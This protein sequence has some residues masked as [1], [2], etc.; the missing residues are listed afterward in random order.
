MA[1]CTHDGDRPSSWEPTVV[2]MP[3]SKIT[4][5]PLK[6]F[7]YSTYCKQKEP[8][9]TI[10]ACELPHSRQCYLFQCYF[11]GIKSHVAMRVYYCN[12]FVFC[13]T[14]WGK[15]YV[16]LTKWNG[17][18]SLLRRDSE[19]VSISWVCCL[20]LSAAFLR[21]FYHSAVCGVWEASS[22]I[23]ACVVFFLD[24]VNICPCTLHSPQTCLL[25][26]LD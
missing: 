13:I 18:T 1:Q 11:T 16:R 22:L 15:E 14:P 24:E 19:A 25:F 7:I 5:C 12:W 21:A 4:H 26:T 8:D 6:M 10:P 9:M 3:M 20:N 2:F 17:Q 23:M